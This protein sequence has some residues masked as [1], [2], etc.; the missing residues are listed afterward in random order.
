M[1][2]VPLR[3]EGKV[4]V[5]AWTNPENRYSCLEELQA[6]YPLANIAVVTGS[7]LVVVDIDNKGGVNGSE[8]LRAIPGF[9]AADLETYTVATPNNGYH[10]YFSTDKDIRCRTGLLPGVDIR[11]EGGYV[12]AP[13]SRIKGIE[14]KVI[15][16]NEVKPIPQWLLQAVGFRIRNGIESYT[17]V[18]TPNEGGE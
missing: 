16:E 4:P 15:T 5:L 13:P 6:R 9:L 7:G 1:Q 10:Y 11:G 8:S 17:V 2:F 14:Y 12:V 3:P 18:K